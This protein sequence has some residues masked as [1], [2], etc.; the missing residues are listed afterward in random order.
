[1]RGGL[2]SSLASLACLFVCFCAGGQDR[3]V[4]QQNS[5]DLPLKRSSQTSEL[6]E[7]NFDRVAASV[8]QLKVILLQDAGLLV[9]LKRWV[10]KEA[11]DNGQVIADEDLTDTAVFERLAKDVKFR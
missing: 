8:A 10:A 3:G 9:E 11:S 4:Q 6:A 5:K 1:M 7:D 2:A